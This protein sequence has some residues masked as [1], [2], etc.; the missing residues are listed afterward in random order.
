M[1]HILDEYKPEGAF[2]NRSTIEAELQTLKEKCKKLEK[3]HFEM[4][5]RCTEI[6]KINRTFLTQVMIH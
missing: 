5:G 4:E 6:A 2:G 1:I 3:K